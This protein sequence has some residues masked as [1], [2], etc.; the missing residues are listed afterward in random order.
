MCTQQLKVLLLGLKS[1]LLPRSFLRVPPYLGL[2]PIR[3]IISGIQ[4]AKMAYTH[5]KT[6]TMD[7]DEGRWTTDKQARAP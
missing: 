1:H 3:S 5:K 7:D 2:V 6:R 4:L